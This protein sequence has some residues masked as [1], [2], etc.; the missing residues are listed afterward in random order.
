MHQFILN[1]YHSSSQE[2]TISNGTVYQGKR[3]ANDQNVAIFELHISTLLQLQHFI[4]EFVT[5]LVLRTGAGLNITD[6]HADLS[7][8]AIIFAAPL[9][10]KESA[11]MNNPFQL[12]EL[13]NIH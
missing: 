7:Q 8:N 6:W 4:N 10:K 12:Q 5:R 2:E 1:N 9:E 11:S 3:R 13:T